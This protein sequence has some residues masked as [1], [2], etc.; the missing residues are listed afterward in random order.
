MALNN[1]HSQR[2]PLAEHELLVHPQTYLTSIFKI[3]T[4][5]SFVYAT[6]YHVPIYIHTKYEG[7]ISRQKSSAPLTGKLR[8]RWPHFDMRRSTTFPSKTRPIQSTKQLG[9]GQHTTDKNEL[10]WPW[11][12]FSFLYATLHHVLIYIPTKYKGNAFLGK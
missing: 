6:L 3:V 9:I 2:V 5:T 1:N 4:V 11:S 10:I 12:L 7:I 8:S